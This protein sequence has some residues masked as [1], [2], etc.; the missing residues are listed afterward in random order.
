MSQHVQVS[1]WI[2]DNRQGDFGNDGEDERKKNEP[3]RS[4][5]S[6]AMTKGLMPIFSHAPSPARHQAD[7]YFWRL[8]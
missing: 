2:P 4:V 3:D 1:S 7:Q 6:P 8:A 5:S